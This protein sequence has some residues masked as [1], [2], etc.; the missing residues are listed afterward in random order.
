MTVFIA[1][2]MLVTLLA[3]IWLVRPLLWPAPTLGVSSDRLNAAIYRDQLDALDRDLARGLI[4]ATDHESTKDELQ[5]R[6]LDD[7]AGATT[8]QGGVGAGSLRARRWMAAMLVVLLPLASGGMY[9]W[10]G[11]TAALNPGAAQE[12]ANQKVEQMVANLVARLQANPNDP[13]GWTMLARSYKVM[14]RLDEAERAFEKVGDSINTDA[15]ALIDYADLLA[16]K[17]DLSL[18]GRPLELV[19]R[20]LALE[21]RHPMGLMMSGVAA[22]RRADYAFAVVQWEKLLTVLEPDSA[23]AQDT[24]ANLDAAR[25]KLKGGGDKA[26]RPAAPGAA[27]AVVTPEQI[28]Q[29]VEKLAQ[30]LKAQPDDLAGWAQLARA[31]KVQGRLDEAEQAY[32]K[33]GKL[34]EQDA[35]LLT[36][37]ADLLAMRAGNQLEGRPLEMV[38]R[39]LALKPK[40]PVA[41][42]MAGSAAYRRADYALAAQHWAVALEV[43]PPNSRDAALVS[44]E[45]A[46]AR[47]KAK[48]PTA[49][50]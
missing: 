48:I 20:A 19:D 7:V 37:F 42:M 27:G 13:K 34:L 11:D 38:N 25:E 43:L 36:Q 41:L 31:Y 5:L 4:S 18:A 16:V 44:A 15:N 21:P 12:A 49:K 40:H 32:L 45:L 39:A 30:R 50:P 46:D 2:A 28:N 24:Q 3:V 14:G 17:A 29:M 23:E 8:P 1:S 47:T 9:A 35:D 22:Y 10:L 33:T 6:L 26:K